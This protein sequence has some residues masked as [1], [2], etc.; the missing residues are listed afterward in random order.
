MNSTQAILKAQPTGV[1]TSKGH[2]KGLA[3]QQ[4]TPTTGVAIEPQV[5]PMQYGMTQTSTQSPRQRGKFIRMNSPQRLNDMQCPHAQF[6]RMKWAANSVTTATTHPVSRIHA[7]LQIEFIRMNSIRTCRLATP[8]HSNE[9]TQ[10][11][12]RQEKTLHSRRPSTVM[13]NHNE[14]FRRLP[15]HKQAA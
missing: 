1:A 2:I 8:V 11:T 9:S 5:Q 7:C 13:R 4:S 3:K 14:Y 15:T 10:H 12:N 6:I